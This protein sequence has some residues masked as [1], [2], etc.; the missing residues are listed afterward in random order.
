MESPPRAFL[1]IYIGDKATYDAQL[2]AYN[3]TSTLLLANCTIYGLPS[4]PEDLSDEQQ[5]ILEDINV[6]ALI[7]SMFSKS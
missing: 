4:T 7:L 2:S 5:G 3:R 1:D 6:I